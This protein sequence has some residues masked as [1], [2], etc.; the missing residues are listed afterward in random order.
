MKISARLVQK[1]LSKWKI[2]YPDMTTIILGDFQETMST[3]DR[4][5]LGAFRQD[6]TRDSIIG[7]LQDSHES[8]VRKRNPNISY[9][10]R[11]GDQGARG[12]DHIFFPTDNK[13][14]DI[15]VDA[16]IQRSVGANYFP[17]DH[18]LLTCSIS[19]TSQNNNCGGR[20][21]TKF[22]YNKIFSIK[23]SQSGKLGQDIGFNF[24]QFK[25]CAKF[26]EQ[27]EL[28]KKLQEKTGD[29]SIMTNAYLPEIEDRVDQLFPSLW[30]DGEVQ[31][32]DGSKNKLVEIAESQ[33]AELSFILNSF[34]R[35]IKTVMTEFKLFQDKN[36]NDSAGTT[37]GRLMKRNG[38]K[39]FNNLPVPTKLQY[40]QKEVEAKLNQVVKNIYWLK[41]FDIRNNHEHAEKNCMTQEEFWNQWSIILK[42]DTLR[43]KAAA[44]ATAYTDEST[45]LCILRQ[46]NTS[47]VRR[48]AATKG[49]KISRMLNPLMA[50][51]FLTFPITS[52]NY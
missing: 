40:V 47:A 39:I 35:A 8:I 2:Q 12:I 45:D 36:N 32:V 27:L 41:E 42:S 13:F 29:E 52:P 43:R 4:D 22:D 33:A 31:K 21:K 3:S 18:S 51:L 9:V 20:E 26:K 49:K 48:M 23:M 30:K 10:T 11:F 28:F 44:A 5:N 25:N 34:N 6:L 19:R 46:S 16:K 15:C 50:I 37:R 14:S 7:G 17:S 24:S 38:F 1:I